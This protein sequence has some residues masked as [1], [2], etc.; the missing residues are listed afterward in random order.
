MKLENDR[1]VAE[2][3]QK[4]AEIVCLQKKLA[5]Q[6]FQ[7]RNELTDNFQQHFAKMEESYETRIR[8]AKELVVLPYKH[9]VMMA[10]PT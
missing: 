8:S 10:I 3:E 1:L 7:L 4:S 5:I 9:Q 6:E 2:A